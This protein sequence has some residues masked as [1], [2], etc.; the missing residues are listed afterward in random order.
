MPKVGKPRHACDPCRL[1]K[2]SCVYL[3]ADD[4]DQK[5]CERCERMGEK[6]L[7]QGKPLTDA[8]S[9]HEMADLL[10]MH[11]L[12]G[13][14]RT[15]LASTFA[16]SELDIL[17]KHW[18][19]TK[20]W[21]YNHIFRKLLDNWHLYPILTASIAIGASGNK[22]LP[23][24]LNVDYSKTDTLHEAV[25]DANF[26]IISLAVKQSK[27]IVPLVILLETLLSTSKAG[28]G[29]DVDGFINLRS[30]LY[31]YALLHS[32]C[33]MV[34]VKWNFMRVDDVPTNAYL[35]QLHSGEGFVEPKEAWIEMLR[36]YVWTTIHHEIT[37]FVNLNEPVRLSYR[38]LAQVRVPLPEACTKVDHWPEF[39]STNSIAWILLSEDDPR[40]IEG[41]DQL[42][43]GDNFVS[44]M[45][46]LS[47]ILTAGVADS[48]ADPADKM[49]M[50]GSDDSFADLPSQQDPIRFWRKA[51]DDVLGAVPPEFDVSNDV[52]KVWE[53]AAVCWG[54]TIATRFFLALLQLYDAKLKLG[55]WMPGM[56]LVAPL[57]KLSDRIATD[58]L[59]HLNRPPPNPKLRVPGSHV[60]LRDSLG[61]VRLFEDANLETV[62]V[63]LIQI[64][65]IFGVLVTACRET[66]HIFLGHGGLGV[67]LRTIF[68]HS[69]VCHVL[70]T[71]GRT[72]LIAESTKDLVRCG[73]FLLEVFKRTV[74][75]LPDWFDTLLRGG[76]VSHAT[77]ESLYAASTQDIVDGTL[78]LLS[79]NKNT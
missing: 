26:H 27:P 73:E 60:K 44:E 11:K 57:R 71:H 22:P 20:S 46:S 76:N 38:Q 65:H 53:I 41:L 3:E 45:T 51:I 14:V 12:I 61:C 35:H 63:D 21:M 78:R 55:A 68:I 2:V 18:F 16:M 39:K 69:L 28:Y 25:W 9:E 1:K 56:E 48:I 66:P 31:R 15:V 36:Q 67:A 74:G 37:W 32:L 40:R 10:K 70:D 13:R 77:I 62:V 19:A 58:A 29:V 17:I 47:K 33:Q 8:W 42:K 75:D 7:V 43:N 49:D 6:C 23:C 64:S 72:D 30:Q 79:E 54:G 50:Y 59:A 34:V 4:G 5:I 52:Q 24:P